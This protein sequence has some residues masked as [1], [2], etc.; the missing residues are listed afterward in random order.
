M[1]RTDWEPK[2]T[3]TGWGPRTSIPNTSPRPVQDCPDLES[4]SALA[5][6]IFS[7]WGH[8]RL[9]DVGNREMR[10]RETFETR[11]KCLRVCKQ[12]AVLRTL[13]LMPE[14][15]EELTATVHEVSLEKVD[16]VIKVN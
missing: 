10:A 2:T 8:S 5:R 12:W 11:N 16:R 1:I 6:N 14:Q 4:L 9:V 13:E 7:G 15:V 3:I